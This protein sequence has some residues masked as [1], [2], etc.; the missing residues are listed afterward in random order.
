MVYVCRENKEK[1]MGWDGTLRDRHW[2]RL[3]TQDWKAWNLLQRKL[4]ILAWV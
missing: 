3:K 1:V 2:G 4:D